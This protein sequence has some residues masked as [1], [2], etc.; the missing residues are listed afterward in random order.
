MGLLLFLYFQ[1]NPLSV[2]R[3]KNLGSCCAIEKNTT[4]CRH[5]FTFLEDFTPNR[6]GNFFLTVYLSKQDND[7]MYKTG[8]TT[9]TSPI[10]FRKK[11]DILK[12]TKFTSIKNGHYIPLKDF[13]KRRHSEFQKIHEARFQDKCTLKLYNN[14]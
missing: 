7:N 3:A 11:D 8:R 9:I 10:F 2:R 13:E 4:S 1:N 12:S 14:H 5:C 6:F